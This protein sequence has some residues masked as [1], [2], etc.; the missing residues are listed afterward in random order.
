[1]IQCWFYL[2]DKQ[3]WIDLDA[4]EPIPHGTLVLFRYDSF[5][6][7]PC[8]GLVWCLIQFKPVPH[9]I[10]VDRDGSE[11]PALLFFPLS[12]VFRDAAVGQVWRKAMET[13]QDGSN[14]TK[15]TGW[16]DGCCGQIHNGIR[17]GDCCKPHKPYSPEDSPWSALCHTQACG[18]GVHSMLRLLFPEMLK[19]FRDLQTP[20]II[21]CHVPK[22]SGLGWEHAQCH[23]LARIR[24]EWW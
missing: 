8:T 7:P 21:S 10:L 20:I 2:R 13:L 24:K 18:S 16:E 12:Q 11:A 4:S 3:S 9:T 17:F 1:M 6:S 19:S 5:T 22:C 15:V 23:H 14:I